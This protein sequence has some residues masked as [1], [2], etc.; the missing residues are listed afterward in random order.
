MKS[1][2]T[3]R[4]G[5]VIGSQYRYFWEPQFLTD[6]MQNWT[7]SRNSKLGLDFM[8]CWMVMDIHCPE[9]S[10]ARGSSP[11]MLPMLAGRKRAVETSRPL[12]WSR[13]S[14]CGYYKEH[15]IPVYSRVAP[16]PRDFPFQIHSHVPTRAVQFTIL[17]IIALGY[18]SDVTPYVSELS[19]ILLPVSKS[20]TI[21]KTLF[22]DIFTWTIRKKYH[23][24]AGYPICR[25]RV[26]RPRSKY[27]QS[28]F[29]G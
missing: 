25:I 20:A 4:S 29:A 28:S 3:R 2:V 19:S 23:P 26:S 21:D 1:K 14:G 7:A 16:F 15:I 9:I 11:A 8:F 24:A 6:T 13:T 22:F 10:R 17:S 5:P 27:S 18:K 12:R